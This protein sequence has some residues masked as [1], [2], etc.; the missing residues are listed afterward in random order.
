MQTFPT[1]CSDEALD[2]WT[3]PKLTGHQGDASPAVSSC[4]DG[5]DERRCGVKP[6]LE[7]SRL[8]RPS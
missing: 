5:S 6:R 4:R 7:L 8:A 2:V 1:I 3:N